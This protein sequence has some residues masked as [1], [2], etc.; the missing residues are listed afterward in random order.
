MHGLI[1]R[2]R[3]ASIV[4]EIEPPHFVGTIARAGPGPDAAVIDHLVD[5]LRTMRGGTPRASHFARRF[6]TVHAGHR[7]EE[8]AWR[9]G[10]AGVIARDPQ[11][12]HLAA[13]F[14][15]GLANDRYVVFRRACSDAGVAAAK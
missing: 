10:I 2:I 12:V 5:A 4:E 15:L 6:F 3:R 13:D 7:L 8:A 14:D 11:P 1:W 9:R